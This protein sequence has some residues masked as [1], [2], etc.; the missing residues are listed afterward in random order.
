MES[1]QHRSHRS[2]CHLTHLR[3]SGACSHCLYY[4]LRVVV[5]VVGA[6][7]YFS[8]K[9]MIKITMRRRRIGAHQDD[10]AA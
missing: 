7:C 9:V 8:T 3:M 5:D 10:D 4:L 6:N 2:H 1:R